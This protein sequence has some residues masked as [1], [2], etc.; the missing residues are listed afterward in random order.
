M[1]GDTA[2]VAL[3]VWAVAGFGIGIAYSP[4]SLAA[5]GY[6]QPGEEGRVTASVQ[7]SDVFGTALG[8]GVAGA[9]VAIVHQHGLNPRLGLG[10]A[11]AVAAVV[12]MVGLAV[13]PRLPRRL[14]S[15]ATAPSTAR[16]SGKIAGDP[17]V[18]RRDDRY[19]RHR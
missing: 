16:A 18:D 3:L 1:V 4:I 12:T 9:A 19:P 13:T 2:L 5:L 8:T 15:E 7:L 14:G 10:L 11:F 6:A 17:P